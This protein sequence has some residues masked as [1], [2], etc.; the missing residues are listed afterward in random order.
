MN[1]SSPAHQ[2][3]VQEIIASERACVQAIR[4]VDTTQ[5]AALMAD[6]YAVIADDGRV[7]NKAEDLASYSAG[8]RHWEF[9]ESDEYGVRV[10][11]DS[12]ML[13]GRWRASVGSMPVIALTMP[14][15][16]WPTM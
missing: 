15:A 8:D 9:A 12:A 14:R 13:I 3:L 10:Y 5:M 11:G 7:R 2:E 6:E 4:D 16:L 1:T